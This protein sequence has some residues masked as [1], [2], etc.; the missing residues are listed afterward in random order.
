MAENK[1]NNKRMRYTKNVRKQLDKAEESVSEAVDL[2]LFSCKPLKLR[3]KAILGALLKAGLYEEYKEKRDNILKRNEEWN[4]E[5]ELSEDTFD[6]IY[7]LQERYYNKI[8]TGWRSQKQ[9]KNLKKPVR[10]TAMAD[11]KVW[12]L[13]KIYDKACDVFETEDTEEI[14][15]KLEELS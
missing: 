3:E 2:Q 6:E 5:M 8:G 13:F 10:L 1:K 9:K 12:E 7:L 4:T 14:K 11:K 15:E